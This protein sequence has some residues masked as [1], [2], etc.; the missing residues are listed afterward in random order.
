MPPGFFSIFDKIQ[1]CYTSE[2]IEKV[3]NEY[4][5]SLIKERENSTEM[6]LF[7]DEDSITEK[8][9]FNY[10]KFSETLVEKAIENDID[11]SV[12]INDLEGKLGKTHPIV[13]LL[14]QFLIEE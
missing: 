14:K 1:Y 13:V 6:R 2:C 3:V 9:F 4:L 8:E 5:Y 12:V 7:D 10:Y 11:L